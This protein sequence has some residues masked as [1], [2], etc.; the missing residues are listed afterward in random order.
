MHHI[1]QTGNKLC[2]NGSRF[3]PRW[4]RAQVQIPMSVQSSGMVVSV[5]SL[6][7]L[8]LRYVQGWCLNSQCELK[9]VECSYMNALF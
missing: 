5:L 9:V 7:P 2:A 6:D 1:E 3:L 8:S 4:K